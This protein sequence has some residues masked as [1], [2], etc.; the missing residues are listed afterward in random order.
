MTRSQVMN[1]GV[2]EIFYDTHLSRRKY[3]LKNILFKLQPSVPTTAKLHLCASDRC[4]WLG[5]IDPILS[6]NASSD[7]AA[8]KQIS[9]KVISSCVTS[10]NKNSEKECN[11]SSQAGNNLGPGLWRH[12]C[13]ICVDVQPE[14]KWD[15]GRTCEKVEGIWDAFHS[16]IAVL[17]HTKKANLFQPCC[18]R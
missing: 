1:A 18:K 9:K 12:W 5:L 6:F 7:T 17:Q 15:W 2:T 11:R 13:K 4:K 10:N 14:S 16:E 8:K 3:V